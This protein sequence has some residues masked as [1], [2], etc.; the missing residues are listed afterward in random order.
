M[1]LRTYDAIR[2]YGYRQAGDMSDNDTIFEM[3]IELPEAPIGNPTLQTYEQQ[4]TV[5]LECLPLFNPPRTEEIAA[6]LTSDKLSIDC[7]IADTIVTFV[8]QP[9]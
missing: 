5:I 2:R 1:P 7:T 9:R 4:K 8:M 3:T 6:L